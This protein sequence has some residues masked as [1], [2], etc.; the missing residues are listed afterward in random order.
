MP[1]I[2]PEQKPPSPGDRPLL[3]TSASCVI[4]IDNRQIQNDISLVQLDQKV[5]GHHLLKVKIRQ[6]GRASSAQDFDDPSRY[7]AFLGKSISVNIRPSG[8]VVDESKELEFI[9]VVSSIG[10]ENSIDGINT[11]VITGMSPTI[12]LDGPRKNAFF[13]D[14]TASEIIGSILGNYR[15][16]LGTQESTSGTLKYVVQYR[17]TDYEFIMRLA[18][19]SGKFAYYNGREFVLARASGSSPEELAWRETLGAFTLGL[20]T[21]TPE[22]ESY[23][24][25]YEQDKVFSQNTSSIPAQSSLSQ[26]SQLSPDASSEIYTAPSFAIPT[27]GVDDAQSL[28]EFLTAKKNDALGRMIKC[29]GL[30]IVPKVGVGRC[31]RVAGMNQ[32]DAVYWVNSIRHVFDESGKYHNTFECTPLDA[33]FPPMRYRRFPVTDLQSAKVVDNNDPDKLGRVK[34]K[35]HW[36]QS[37]ESV[38]I[39]YVAAH[40]G[41]DRGWY[42]LPEID[43]EVL[44][45]YENG[46]PDLPIALGALYNKTNSPLAGACNANNDIKTFVTK[47]GNQIFFKDE[48]GSEQLNISM[49]DGKNI[50]SMEL[51]GPKISIESQNGDISL[52]AKNVTIE[53]DQKF[54]VKTTGD[55][56]VKA[57]GN[58]NIESSMN[59]T[60]KG[61]VK[62]GVEGT[63]VEVKGNPIKLN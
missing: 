50:I 9:G 54:E 38:W 41:K 7:T 33:A 48:A 11:V 42:C 63:I 44:V 21:T 55:T 45:G 13:Y 57:Q 60:L 20:G 24:Y 35:F 26:I 12:A 18:G 6:V 51:S 34:V 32:I 40:A 31:V 15:V 10:L 5:I 62:T 19:E 25:N 2:R 49:K 47:G 30:S 23:I 14:Q 28:D 46:N 4:R 59:L 43:D 56:I 53:C 22:F 27:R 8:G 61:G 29:R 37:S 36:A 17:E 3:E 52:K 16:T 39:R 1:E 58:A